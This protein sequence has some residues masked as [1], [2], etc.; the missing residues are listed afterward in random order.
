M[1]KRNPLFVD[2][3]VLHGDRIG[4]QIELKNI[5]LYDNET[6]FVVVTLKEGETQRVPMKV[7]ND[8]TYQAR[9]W[10][11]HQKTVSLRF[12][13]EKKGREV[14]QSAT[15]QSRAKYA[16]IENWEPAWGEMADQV[17][18]ID[19]NYSMP[20]PDVPLPADYASTV[21]SLIEKWDL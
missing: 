4:T 15:Y 21:A 11:G 10:M 14:L 17:K 3:T 18:T 9:V 16:I 1:A 8:T 7:L 19:S 5:F 2:S 12:V 6:V 13:I 20:L